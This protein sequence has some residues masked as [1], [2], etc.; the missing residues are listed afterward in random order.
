MKQE[1]PEI[2]AAREQHPPRSR[3]CG[4]WFLRPSVRRL[5]G[6]YKPW[7]ETTLHRPAGT[8]L[9]ATWRKLQGLVTDAGDGL[10]ARDHR[11]ATRA[12]VMSGQGSKRCPPQAER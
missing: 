2:A 6:K 9:V 3:R 7:S 5:A 10:A 4:L 12:R 8:R 1:I 11:H